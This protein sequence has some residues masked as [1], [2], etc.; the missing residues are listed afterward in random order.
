MHRDQRGMVTA[1]VVRLVV[2][3]ALL[4]LAVE[5]TGQVVLAQI[6]ASNAAGTAAQAGA[7]DYYAK[8]NANHAE[9]M[10][11]AALQAD[12]P[13]ATMTSFSV[14]QDGT[15]TVSVAETATTLFIQHLPVLKNFT[16][17][18]ATE[19]EIHTLA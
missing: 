17:Q 14:D 7:D 18:H 13:H 1:Y 19:H 12:D 11:V 16:I 4:V 10:A 5:E 6:H 2:I 9:A 8:K 3:F 15:V